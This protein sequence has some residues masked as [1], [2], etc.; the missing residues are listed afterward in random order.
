MLGEISMHVS[1]FQAAK[2][3]GRTVLKL[4]RRRLGYS[5]AAAAAK[6]RLRSCHQI[7]FFFSVEVRFYRGKN[8]LTQSQ[9]CEHA[10]DMSSKASFASVDSLVTE[11]SGSMSQEAEMKSSNEDINS[12]EHKAPKLFTPFSIR[13]ILEEDNRCAYTLSKA[14]SRFWP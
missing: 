11:S 8:F 14:G 7:G 10:I 2:E 12:S 9:Y 1:F 6:L 4:E 5:E 3:R 13:D